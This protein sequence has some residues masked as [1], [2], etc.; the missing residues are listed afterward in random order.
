MT[1]LRLITAA[2]VAGLLGLAACD[3]APEQQPVREQAAAPAETS[4]AEGAER[5]GGEATSQR[6]SRQD[7][8]DPR[9]LPV[10]AHEDGTPMWAA[11]QRLTA[12]EAAERQFEKNGKDFGAT[13]V[14]QYVDRTHD[15][16]GSPPEGTLRHTRSNGDKLLYDPNGNVFAVA[17]K[18]GAPRTMFKPEDGMDYWEKQKQGRDRRRQ[19]E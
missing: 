12:A 7:R 2:S 5:G 10:A 1:T 19:A 13:T 6:A 14:A 17:T 8:T 9:T 3:R 4:T 11:N 16:V 18:D 15:F